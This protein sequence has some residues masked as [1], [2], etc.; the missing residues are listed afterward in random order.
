MIILLLVFVLF[1]CCVALLEIRSKKHNEDKKKWVKSMMGELR[2]LRD[3][4]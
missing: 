4:E 2:S 1:V 3:T